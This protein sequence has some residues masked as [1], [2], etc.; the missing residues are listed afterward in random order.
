MDR[1]LHE[2]PAMTNSRADFYARMATRN[3][4]PLW[5]VLHQLLAKEPVTEATPHKWDYDECRPYIM[6]SAGI[7][8]AEEA[9]RRV[10][11]L[12]NPTLEGRS[13]ITEA[14]YAGLQLIMPGEVAP[15]HRH[16][17]AALRFIVEGSGA[18]TAI[19]G[20]RAY[21]EVGDLILTPSWQ[22][23]DHGHTG[24]EPVVW[25][26][27]LDIPLVRYL[28]PVFVEPYPEAEF[29]EGRPSGDN[30][31][32]YG[33]NMLPLGASFGTQNSP[34]FHY[35]YARTREALEGLSRSG[36]PDARHGFK[37]EYI[38]P[39][40]GGPVMPTIATYMQKLPGGFR[41]DAYRTTAAWVYSVAEGAGRTTIGDEVFEWKERDTFVVPTWYPHSHEADGDAFLFSFTDQPVQQ[42]LGL[43]REDAGAAA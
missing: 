10:M 42:K 7:I 18:Y 28:G 11:V 22:W 12:E 39:A 2:K 38:N 17:P 25:L 24:D 13:C 9:E 20:E 41:G 36:D 8:S 1:A 43:L 23:H 35:P 19:D 29:P 3:M 4:T 14:L 15:A 21:M 6:E 5:E 33:A 30:M 16:S 27:G 34:V 31:L 32:R 26:D 37:L 40:T